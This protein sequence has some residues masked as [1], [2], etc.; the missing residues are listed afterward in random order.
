MALGHTT[1]SMSL[2][3]PRSYLLRRCVG[4]VPGGSSHTEPE[5]VRLEVVG[6]GGAFAGTAPRCPAPSYQDRRSIVN[7]GAP[8]FRSGCATFGR[9]A[10][11]GEVGE[12]RGEVGQ[13]PSWQLNG[14]VRLGRFWRLREAG[15]CWYRRIPKG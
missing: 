15:W 8:E 13:Q 2:L 14:L 9:R 4:W 6:H 12:E 11:V 7:A 5:E 3:L 1:R 10:A